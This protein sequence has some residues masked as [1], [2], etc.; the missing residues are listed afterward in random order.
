MLFRHKLLWVD[1]LEC[2]NPV[3]KGSQIRRI[4]APTTSYIDERVG[5]QRGRE[6]YMLEDRRGPSD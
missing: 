2:H 4:A 1:Y 6:S 3:A 5:L